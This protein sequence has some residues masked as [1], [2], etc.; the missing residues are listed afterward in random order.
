MTNKEKHLSMLSGLTVKQEAIVKN[1]S[2]Y[3]VYRFYKPNGETAKEFFTYPKARAFAQGIA[4][5]TSLI[6]Q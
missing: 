5:A 3:K 4:F 2:K 6:V 1:G